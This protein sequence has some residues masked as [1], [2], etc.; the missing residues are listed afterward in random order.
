[1][2]TLKVK[3]ELRGMNGYGSDVTL[4]ERT[5]DFGGVDCGEDT[6]EELRCAVSIAEAARDGVTAAL[7]VL[8]RAPPA[9]APVRRIDETA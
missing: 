8:K 9:A 3:V 6:I 2:A 5:V 4:Y 7:D 1:M